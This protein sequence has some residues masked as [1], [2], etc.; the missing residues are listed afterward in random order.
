MRTWAIFKEELRKITDPRLLHDLVTSPEHPETLFLDNRVSHSLAHLFHS[1]GGQ[2]RLSKGMAGG[3]IKTFPTAAETYE[4]TNV[5]G[6]DVDTIYNLIPP[7]FVC[8]KVD[9]FVLT[10]AWELRLRGAEYVASQYIR[11]PAGGFYS[12]DAECTAVGG[13]NAVAGSAANV[14][15]VAWSAQV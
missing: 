9:V 12:I 13:R 6:A 2:S 14:T 4:A 3:A 5:T 11:I 10:F 1:Y 15:I 7:G 8:V